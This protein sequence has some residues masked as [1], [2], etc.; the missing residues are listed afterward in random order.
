MQSIPGYLKDK[1]LFVTGATG[2]LGKAVVVQTLRHVPDVERIYI[3]VRERRLKSGG[4][5]SAE[6]R[7]DQVIASRAFDVLRREW[8][9]AFDSRVR[10]KLKVVAWK[11][12][13]YEELGIDDGVREQLQSEVDIVI[14][15]A[16]T[17]VFDEPVDKALD[18][19]TIGLARVLDFAKGCRDASFL[20]V[21]TAYV[22]GQMT[23]SIP[24]V[25]TPPN[26]S[27]A[28]QLSNGA[29]PHYDLEEQITE[30]QAFSERVREEA[31]T[32][33]RRTEF[34]RQ[35]TRQNRGKRVTQHRLDHQLDAL[36]QRWIKARLVREGL[37]RGRHH[38]WN[39][40][41]TM[42]KAMGEQLI[43]KERGNLPVAIVRPS[44]IESSLQDPEPG[45]LEGLKVADPLIVH[46][47]KGRLTDFP[48]DPNVVL[49]VIPVDIV[50]NAILT[51]L[52]R[53]RENGAIEVY[54]AATGSSNPIRVGEIM[55]YVYEY[56]RANPVLDR[57]GKPIPV[58][59]WRFPT[60]VRFSRWCRLRYQLPMA[61]TRWILERLPE[62]RRLNRMMRK[63][64]RGEA[65]LERVLALSE[66]Y[67]PYTFLNCRFETKN[68]E[69]V[70]KD[71]LPEDRVRF[72]T[73]VD[74]IDW[75]SYVQDTHIPGLHRHV[76]KSELTY[77][78]RSGE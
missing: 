71:M 75:R 38:G 24:E 36:K 40:A 16:A 32:P 72:N 28:Q 77:D 18:Q 23:G 44:I 62:S 49:D 41:Y 15:C 74:R 43:Q 61:V 51:V 68:L 21:S 31:E 55:E 42:T 45:W 9:C 50:A 66:I 57:D 12:L 48:G 60:L 53:I 56:Y 59:R 58:H 37:R 30:I 52:P 14:S 8:G 73:D 1:V 67:A 54:H 29:A 5:Q 65:T 69:R 19:N 25:L 70:Y 33:G 3:S 17:V 34:E 63:V 2:F 7:L 26:T 39:D 78:A 10:E 22:N 35:L 46:F 64:S 4:A 13:E 47:G 76:L 11:G 27:I 20:H 6:T